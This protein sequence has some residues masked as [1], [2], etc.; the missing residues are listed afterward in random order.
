MNRI[1][2]ITSLMFCVS[3]IM[4]QIGIPTQVLANTSEEVAELSNG[5]TITKLEWNNDPWAKGL[6]FSE[7]DKYSN[8]AIDKKYALSINEIFVNGIK[9][10]KYDSDDNLAYEVSAL[11]LRIKPGAFK[12][13]ENKI[14]IKAEGFKD[15]EIQFTKKGDAYTFVSQ[16]DMN[17][18][19]P[20]DT[21]KQT[22]KSLIQEAKKIKKGS[23]SESAFTYLQEAINKAEAKLSTDNQDELL[24]AINE[25]QKAMKATPS[26]ILEDGV[27]TLSF[28]ARK[29]GKQES[30]MLEG[31]FDP[32]VKLTVKNGQM[33]VSMLNTA[34]V[35]FLLDFSIESN[36]VFKPAVMKPMG[37][38]AN[39][40]TY[41]LKEFTIPIENLS[42]LHKGGVLVTAMGGH[43]SDIGHYEKYTMLDMSFS[44]I[45]KGWEDYKY[46]IDEQNAPKGAEQIEKILIRNGY[47]T[48]KDGNISPEELSAIDGELD[49]NGERLTDISYLKGLANVRTLDL[50]GNLIEE[51]PEGLL[52]NLPNLENLYLDANRIQSIPKDFFKNSKKLKQ[53]YISSNKLSALHKADFKGLENIEDI[54]A[55]NNLIMSVEPGTFDGF[56]KL[57]SLALAK[58]KLNEL[59][60]NLFRPLTSLRMVFLEENGLTSI[61]EDLAHA[62]LLEKLYIG[63]NK[64]T[65]LEK[66]TFENLTKLKLVNVRS[67]RIAKVDEGVF[68]N[69]N[70]LEELN[71]FD[72]DLSK[73]SMN[74]LP[75]HVNL[76]NMSLNLR[77]N[78]MAEIDSSLKG[79]LKENKFTP[80]KTEANLRLKVENNNLKWTQNLELLDLLKWYDSSIVASQKELHTVDEYKAML[81][82]Q[83]FA[84]KEIADIL[85]E[86]GYDWDIQTVLQKK[87]AD[88]SFATVSSATTS[89]VKDQVTGE[90]KNLPEGTYRL[91]KT[92]YSTRSNRKEYDFSVISN[93]AVITR[94]SV[95]PTPTPIDPNINTN[96]TIHGEGVQVTGNVGKAVKIKVLPISEGKEVD[97]IRQYLQNSS[98]KQWFYDISLRDV[99]NNH[100]QPDG[101]VLVTLQLPQANMK[102]FKL[103]HY[104]NGKVKEVNILHTDENNVTFETTAFSVFAFAMIKDAEDNVV[105]EDVTG[106]RTQLQNGNKTRNVPSITP[107]SSHS[108]GQEQ[109]LKV[110]TKT[111]SV[112][113]SDSTNFGGYIMLMLSSIGICIGMKVQ[114]KKEIKK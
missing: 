61:P 78:H 86:N 58:N 48:N 8:N 31:A 85:M 93:E 56:T 34:L 74:E 53:F 25:L 42:I 27:Y 33:T 108:K 81:Q 107:V 96:K 54:S 49:L 100:V 84:N 105:K 15:K 50:T 38:Q 11:A 44:D 46:N 17:G 20:V 113:T 92:V 26:D 69:N 71:L 30:S 3:I 91:L 60:L 43:L 72:N 66:K 88:G 22:L 75:K 45:K 102:G 32:H 24:Q 97:A 79:K 76:S 55:G 2:K 19:I 59:P 110:S 23:V 111:A 63:R 35:S 9:Y 114:R 13:G 29:E 7:I 36:G 103:Y 39:D 10:V 52:D 6:D 106:N 14:L 77:M 40:G 87:S 101:K 1:K 28:K 16:K 41:K 83:G 73:F 104:T 95:A 47:D 90:Y 12:E 80:Q 5:T 57:Y 89:E 67:N 70:A 94:K 62:A 64:I 109:Q 18:N 51:L 65:K 4:T 99:L 112:Q 68:K 21:N 98:S 82:K 37:E